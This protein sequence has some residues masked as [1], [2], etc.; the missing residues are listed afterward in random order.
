MSAGGHPSVLL[1]RR[2]GLTRRP[3]LA[4]RSLNTYLIVRIYCLTVLRT[5]RLR[6]WHYRELPSS[7][8]MTVGE[9]K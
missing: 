9:I 7:D 5:A 3:K 2:D 8:K 4:V 6:G 1:K